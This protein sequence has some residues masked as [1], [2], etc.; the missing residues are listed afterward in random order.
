MQQTSDIIKKSLWQQLAAAID[1]L[2]NVIILY[3]LDTW[4]AGLQFFYIAYH[5]VL[6]TDYYLTIPP[7]K[8]ISP[9]PFKIMSNEYGSGKNLY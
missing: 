4:A 1:T 2:N 5:A 6:V 7:E 3:P 9:L 8:F